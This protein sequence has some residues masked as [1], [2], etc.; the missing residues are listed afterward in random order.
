M[1]E[2]DLH[3]VPMIKLASNL[4]IAHELYFILVVLS[5]DQTIGCHYF[6]YI[7]LRNY[8]VIISFKSRLK[9]RVRLHWLRTL[10]H[11]NHTDSKTYDVHLEFRWS[12]KSG[13][14]RSG[15][16]ARGSDIESKGL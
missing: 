6:R 13:L 4:K 2:L 16:L 5:I 7:F 12:M 14:P 11:K 10:I 8:D 15:R 1:C 3:L 9:L